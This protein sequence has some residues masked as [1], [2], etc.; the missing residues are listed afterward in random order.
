MESVTYSLKEM[1]ELQKKLDNIQKQFWELK[2]ILNIRCLN[3]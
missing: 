2:E 1:K 3:H